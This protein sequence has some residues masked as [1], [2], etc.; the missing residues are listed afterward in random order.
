ME[1]QLILNRYRPV[2][3]LGH[4]GHGEV[5]LAYD[6]R[7]ARRVAIKRLPLPI[8]RDGRPLQRA[9]LAEARTAALLNHPNIVTVH[10]WD[11]D[12]DE[13]FI[14]MEHVDGASLA[15]VLD[16]VEGPLDIDEAATVLRDAARALNFAH[17][18]GVLHL[19]LK[20]DNI[21]ITRDGR[22]KVA[23]FGVSVLTNA[24][25]RAIG[26]GGTP[27]YMPPEQLAGDDVDETADVW[28]LAALMFE[29]L[30]GANPFASRSVEGALFKADFVDTPAPS[31][32]RRDL[33]HGVDDILLA[34]LAVH[35]MDR[36]PSVEDFAETLLGHLG[37]PEI[38]SDSLSDVV[39]E[40]LS[41]EDA[42]EDSLL[43]VGVWDRLAGRQQAVRRVAAATVA[44]WLCS[45][46]LLELGVGPVAWAGAALAA[47]AAALAP[48]LGLALALIGATLGLADRPLSAI[49]FLALATP[50]WFLLGRE[51]RGLALFPLLGPVLAAG[52]MAPLAPL[53]LGF[54]FPPVPAA[55]SAA[56][57]SLVVTCAS[58]GAG[59]SPPYATLSPALLFSGE[60]LSTYAS[61]ARVLIASPG[62]LIAAI[63]WA[64][65]AAIMSL[66]C[67]RA[68]RLAAVSGALLGAMV[69]LGG[70]L[71]WSVFDATL[72]WPHRA[73]VVQ[74]VASLIIIAMVI[75]A[76]PPARP[77]PDRPLD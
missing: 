2:D 42:E 77:E 24:V 30:T 21:L 28:G 49:T 29:V 10:E 26:W 35:P 73:S 75:I 66:A 31:D 25:G 67:A 53:A 5:V 22:A 52:R 76:G 34:A 23:D 39:D 69:M 64:I 12:S 6:T 74:V 17:D 70:Y 41:E 38:G 43:Q 27:G 51:G 47:L 40:L 1:R 36:Y 18:N 33:P 63:S 55:A 57:T 11:T 20:P 15:D 45:A 37:D 32:F 72:T 61:G 50:F 19:D 68:T 46:G 44:L 60:Q 65:A 9:G 14:I 59:A 4:G 13:A 58:A 48:G 62:P 7:M 8:D 54:F 16:A 56:L 71:T 3:E